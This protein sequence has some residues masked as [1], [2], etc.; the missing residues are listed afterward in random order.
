MAKARADVERYGWHATGV[1]GDPDTGDPPFV[2]TTGLQRTYKHPE[3]VIAGLSAADVGPHLIASAVAL[4]EEGTVF[5]DG[6]D[7]LNI[8]RGY[9]VRF[10]DVDPAACTLVF[11]VSNQFYGPPV[12]LRSSTF[13]GTIGMQVPRMQLLWPD[14]DGRLP[15]EPGCDP[16]IARAQRIGG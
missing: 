1:F 15:G 3:L 11:S 8:V 10:R 14:R 6:T 7:Y 16:V 13:D 2:Y 4:I 5:Q 9:A 12:S